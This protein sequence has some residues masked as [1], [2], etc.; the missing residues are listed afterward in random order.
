M[1]PI[2]PATDSH[3]QEDGRADDDAVI[4][5]PDLGHLVAAIFLVDL[6]DELVVRSHTHSAAHEEPPPLSKWVA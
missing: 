4:A 6:A 3:H 5:L 1:L 2:A